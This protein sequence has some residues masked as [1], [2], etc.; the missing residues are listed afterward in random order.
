MTFSKSGITVTFNAVLYPA[1]YEGSRHQNFGLSED[2][3]CRVYDRNVREALIHLIIKDTHTNLEAIREFIMQT[4][5][6]R[7]YTFTF[8]P[9]TNHNV[10]NGD[11]GALTVRYWASN[12]MEKQYAYHR[13]QYEII[14]RKEAVITGAGGADYVDDIDEVGGGV[15][16]GH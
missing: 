12:F 2:G 16:G 13:Y 6:Q 15:E 4:V 5:S 9:D 7:L 14:L 8:T 3:T 10:G 11:G 1:N